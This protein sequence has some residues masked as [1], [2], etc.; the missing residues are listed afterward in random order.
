MKRASPRWSGLLIVVL[1]L[2]FCVGSPAD[3]ASNLDRVVH[4]N[5]AAALAS[6]S[7][8]GSP[9]GTLI[10]ASSQDSTQDKK[11]TSSLPAW[12][13]GTWAEESYRD[14]RAARRT[15]EDL[16]ER[17]P[18][19]YDYEAKLADVER[20]IDRLRAA[21]TP[22][23]PSSPPE[24][25][26]ES[27]TREPVQILVPDTI[28]PTDTSTRR[29]EGGDEEYYGSDVFFQDEGI[30]DAELPAESEL[31]VSGRQFIKANLSST[32]YPNDPSRES[33]TDVSVDQQLK[34]RIRGSIADDL[35]EVHIDF[36]D[37]L[38]AV[39][40][41]QTRVFYNGR[42]RDVG[43]AT[44]QANAKF[45]DVQLSLPNSTF[46]SYNKSVFGLSG[47]FELRDFELGGWGPESLAFYGVASEKKGETQKE[48]FSGN[49]QRRVPNPVPDINPIRRT[50]YQPLADTDETARSL[51]V[52]VDSERILLDDQNAED[53]NANTIEGLTVSNGGDEY[54]GDFDVLDEGD[55]YSI[56]YRT[57]VIRLKQ[58]ISNNAVL[59][60]SMTLNNGERISD[61]M[62]K[63]R[64]E[65][66]KFDRYHLLNRYQLASRNIVRN[67]PDRELEIR[68]PNDA[69]RPD[70]GNQTY[71]QLLGMDDNGD[72]VIDDE[73]VDFELGVL[74]FPDTHPF[75]VEALSNNGAETNP[76]IYGSPA[77]RSQYYEIYQEVLVEENTYTLGV[78]VVRESEE[79]TVDG[80]Q[81]ER[82]EDYTIDYQSGFLSFFDHVEID[83]ETT[84]EVTYEEQGSAASRSETF[85]GGRMEATLSE[86]LSMGSTMLT[87]QEQERDE[88]PRVGRGTKST[89]VREFDVSWNPVRSLQTMIGWW[90]GDRWDGYP[91]QDDF[92]MDLRFDWA[93]SS[94]NPAQEGQALVDDFAQLDQRIPFSKSE[95]DWFPGDPVQQF[96]GPPSVLG[97]RS[98]VR[99]D[100][101]ENTGHDPD[102]AEDENQRS[103]RVTL[104]MGSGT[105]P[106]TWA[107]IQQLFSSNGQDLRGYDFLEF[108]VK[109]EKG[110][111][112]GT[113]SVDLG[114]VT[115]N[116]NR[117]G[118]L[119]E[120]ENNNEILNPGEDDG[121]FYENSD[122]RFGENNGQLDSEDL[123]GNGRLDIREGYL[124][125]DS[126]NRST[127]VDSGTTE[128]G[129]TV[130]KVPLRGQYGE[131]R[132]NA[133]DTGVVVSDTPTRSE[134]LRNASMV[135][136]NYE[137]PD[138]SGNERSFLLE[139]MGV[140]ETRWRKADNSDNFR[141]DVK[142]EDE[143][144]R[145]PAP[146][147]SDF[148]EEDETAKGLSFD[149]ENITRSDSDSTRASL[150][151]PGGAE[152]GNFGE[153]NLLFN[154]D[155]YQDVNPMNPNEGILRFGS[156]E[157][158]Y[159]QYRFT[160]HDTGT[161][162]PSDPWVE[163]VGSPGNNWYELS[164]DLE[165][166]EQDLIDKNLSDSDVLRRGGRTIRGTPTLRDVKEFTLGIIGE[167]SGEILFGG[168]SL[169]DAQ[170]EVGEARQVESSMDVADGFLQLNATD[171][172]IDGEFRTIGL[173]NNTVANQFVPQNELTR[174]VDGSVDLN[175]LI[176]DDW[177]VGVPLTFRW[178]DQTTEIPPDRIERIR[179][180]EVGEVQ[181]L[182]RSVNSGLNTPGL[183]PDFSLTWSDQDK[184]VDQEQRER[185]F[186]D[187]ESNWQLSGNHS[188]TFEETVADLVPIGE[189]L[190]VSTNGRYG[191]FEEVRRSFGEVDVDTTTRE[192]V[193]RG[194]TTNF[195]ANPWS[196]LESTAQFDFSDLHRETERIS[197]LITRDQSVDFSLDPSGFYGLNPSYSLGTGIS[198]TYNR[199]G[200]EVTRSVGLNGQSRLRVRTNPR[201][202]W[203][204]LDF[205]SLTYRYQ[206]NSSARYNELGSGVGNSR[207]YNDFY[208]GPS[209][210]V[211]GPALDVGSDSLSLARTRANKNITHSV[212]GQLR[213]WR[214]LD[215]RY[216]LDFSQ[217][218]GQTDNSVNRTDV[219]SLSLN[220]RL[221]LREVSSFVRRRTQNANLNLN[222]NFSRSE[223]SNRLETTH[224]PTLQ[225]ST[226][227]NRRWSTNFN[228]SATFGQELDRE[229][230][231]DRTSYSPSVDFK[232]LVSE[233][234][235]EGTL[236]F[237]NRL[238]VNGNLAAQLTEV[239]RNGEIREDNRQISG[240]LGGSYNI[241][242]KIRARFGGNFTLFRDQF[243][244]A[245]DRNTYGFETSV[246]F[247]F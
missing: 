9:E 56:N 172:E 203:E 70:T 107:S 210:L 57:G 214:H 66:E 48:E 4:A 193:S 227:W 19:L 76:T 44:F 187:L 147:T 65:S 209:W 142:T 40:Q 159:F 189:S 182:S 184:Q 52:Q 206:L 110:A 155:N 171:R 146:G 194:L 183:Y 179:S 104:P 191:T 17:A 196:W 73:F 98:A 129:W 170:E 21:I 116:T 135:R 237:D 156:G 157:D 72:G 145:L 51:P 85:L 20:K 143:D 80:Q 41:Q 222:Y 121:L 199:G 148:R 225:L 27:D 30:V 22:T 241:T 102:P 132:G 138:A 160:I 173:V 168:I 151:L 230:V 127:A 71:A 59:A 54:T 3:A 244:D 93:E 62:I 112:N 174:S 14:L 100:E 178:N 84:V 53:N 68:D 195:R 63:D 26:T 177:D 55:D 213:F 111:G 158:N 82:G 8:D 74:R 87:S 221:Q 39:E 106:D 186:E 233:S 5:A 201:E 64:A 18:D 128:E 215:S 103:M 113:L 117:G 119:T 211:S 78:N 35:L 202:W 118:L 220:N 231:R 136:L 81:L 188:V 97:N 95:Y 169:D 69:N 15:W 190:N 32:S 137:A 232:W 42:E 50:Y 12:V 58:T 46:V 10:L 224:R 92:D 61:F 122:F 31:N 243:R 161:P 1:L 154:L 207:A 140:V 228:L 67:D 33:R 89:T 167:G 235:E 176:P 198:E 77:N 101:V 162:E 180:E 166:F 88:V 36:D 153:I 216:N 133:T 91:W 23:E 234:D 108:W 240:D 123:N 208:N 60:V 2:F 115:E 94:R 152:V 49:N 246:D 109:W 204:E 218:I 126:V 6:R 7:T 229:L 185:E 24:P 163:S 217:N 164:V 25:T 205:L 16:R 219:T 75:T 139:Q 245:N 28:G 150:S 165:S 11:K 79:V 247:R 181:T 134:V 239:I 175:R 226:R 197:G 192:E 99:F 96:P 105:N 34:V 242:E 238:E 86:N 43:L 37:S 141:L 144:M 13:R 200:D 125:F 131:A 130:Y 212:G 38:P 47:Q 120:D 236:W 83:D 90:E 114:Q 45:G 223:A 29:T 124:H 149:F